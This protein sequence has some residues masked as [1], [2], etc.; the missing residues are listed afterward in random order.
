M[1]SQ[2]IGQDFFV[3]NEYSISAIALY[4]YTY[5]PEGVKFNLNS[6]PNIRNWLSNLEDQK[7]YKPIKAEIL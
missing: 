6:Y 1:E 7:G 3:G 2:L 4:A 5:V